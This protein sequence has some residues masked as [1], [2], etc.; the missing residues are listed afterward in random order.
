MLMSKPASKRK[1]YKMKENYIKKYI[2]RLV[3]GPEKNCV[4]FLGS[5]GVA[6]VRISRNNQK[7][8]KNFHC[9]NRENNLIFCEIFKGI[10]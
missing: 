5:L 6:T 1:N 9:T 8:T 10:F 2:T 4:G 7:K 3:F